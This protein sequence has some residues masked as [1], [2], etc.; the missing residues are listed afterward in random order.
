M[1]AIARGYHVTLEERAKAAMVVAWKSVPDQCLPCPEWSQ[2]PAP[3][4]QV[5]VQI[6]KT[7]TELAKE[8]DT[9]QQCENWYNSEINPERLSPESSICPERGTICP[10]VQ[11]ISAE[12]LQEIA[13]ARNVWFKRVSSFLKEAFPAC[14]KCGSVASYRYRPDVTALTTVALCSICARDKGNA[15]LF[16]VVNSEHLS[17]LHVLFK[18]M[19]L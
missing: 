15:R 7:L 4:Q 9:C 14:S 12:R 2:L 17:E 13:A 3:V 6:A 19:R 18:A 10:R 1:C 11:K 16:R 8:P 5:W